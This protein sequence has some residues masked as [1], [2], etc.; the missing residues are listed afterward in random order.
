MLLTIII[1]VGAL[2]AMALL[3][4]AFR[5]PSASKSVKRRVELIKERHGD[6]VA[7]TAQAQIRKCSPNARARSR[8]WPR[9]SSPS[10][11]C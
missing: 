1:A 11:R 10:R 3:Y 7:G 4:N 6:V 9:R 2:G 5:G 8:A